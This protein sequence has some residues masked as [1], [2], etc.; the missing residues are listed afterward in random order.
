MLIAKDI[1]EEEEE[2]AEEGPMAHGRSEGWSRG[3]EEEGISKSM[4]PSPP[5][6]IPFPYLLLLHPFFNSPPSQYKPFIGF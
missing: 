2:E 3:G 6:L 1:A 4:P 5:S